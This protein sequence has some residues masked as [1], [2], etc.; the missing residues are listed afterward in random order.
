[1]GLMKDINEYIALPQA[2]R[3]AHLKLDEPCI[4]RGGWRNSTSFYCK[5]LLAHILDTTIP[6]GHKIHACHACHNAICTNPYHLY[7][8][9]AKENFT[10]ALNNGRKGVWE[11]TVEKYGLEQAKKR[12][13]RKK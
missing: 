1:M 7:W 6:T 5:G 2:E 10:D 12:N 13:S 9:T 3:Q 11:Y 8:G 4:D